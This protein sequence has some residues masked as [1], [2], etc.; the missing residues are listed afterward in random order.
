MT[1]NEKYQVRLGIEGE[2]KK[3]PCEKKK[4]D[5]QKSIGEGQKIQSDW[6]DTEYHKDIKMNRTSLTT[7]DNS[8]TGKV[9]PTCEKKKI[10]K[11][12]IYIILNKLIRRMQCPQSLPSC[13]T[14]RTSSI[15]TGSPTSSLKFYPFSG[16]L[17]P[18]A[19]ILDFVFLTLD[20][21]FQSSFSLFLSARFVSCV[22]RGTSRERGFVFFFFF[23][24]PLDLF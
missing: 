18:P 2:S 19:A 21:I 17:S 20:K 15:R 23:F 1:F 3:I 9:H 13:D 7:E 24:I 6:N 16:S 22:L 11:I 8:S 4:N 14:N 10:K 12:S 5:D